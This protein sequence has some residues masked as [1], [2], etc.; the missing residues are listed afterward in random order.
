MSPTYREFDHT[1]DLGIEVEAESLAGLFEEAAFGMFALLVDLEIVDP[2]KPV[3]ISLEAADETELLLKWLSELNYLHLTERLLF[4]RFVIKEV[5]ET[6][7]LA[8]AF[9]VPIDPTR[10][11]IQTEIKAVTY[12]DLVIEQRNDHWYARIIFDV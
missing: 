4:G 10:H 11:A 6:H 3:D 12:H 9:S 1:G 8:R 5:S 7:L 2:Q